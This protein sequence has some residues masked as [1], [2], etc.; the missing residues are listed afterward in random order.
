MPCMSAHSKQAGSENHT[1]RKVQLKLVNNKQYNL[2]SNGPSFLAILLAYSYQSYYLAS[3]IRCAC[4]KSQF[5][6]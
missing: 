2:V 6:M 4:T 3:F 5:L 1:S